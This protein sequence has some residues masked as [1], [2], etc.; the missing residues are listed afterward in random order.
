MDEIFR[1]DSV[2]QY[3]EMMGVETLHPLVSVIDLSKCDPMRH[4]RYSVGFYTVFLKEIK[5]GDIRYGRNYYDY[6]EGTLVFLAPGQVIGI[7]DNGQSF[8]PKGRA[9]LFHP[10]LLR[11]TELGRTIKEY[12][13]FSYEVNEALHLSVQER[14]TVVECLHNIDTELRHSI[15][16]H[17]RQLIVS[18]IGLLLNYCVRFYERQFI[19]RH[20]VNSDMLSRFE[21]LL[22]EY[23]RS[24]A[25]QNVGLPSVRYFAEKLCLSANYFGDLIKRETGRSAQEQIQTYVVER[26][27]ERIFDTKKSVSEIAYELGFQYPQ[28]FS[29]MFKKSVGMSPLEFRMQRN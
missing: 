28:H 29:R 17:S 9:L 5:C 13:F 8:Q 11:G 27:K 6:Q 1:V 15:D 16:K 14:Q 18:N 24:G 20:H 22:D 21:Q 19:T 23:F 4:M 10:D 26:A 7:E 12:T 2:C 3:N 25:P